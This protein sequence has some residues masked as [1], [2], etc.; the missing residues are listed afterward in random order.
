MN[1]QLT[2]DVQNCSFNKGA[3]KMDVS[4]LPPC[5]G[6]RYIISYQYTDDRYL[7]LL[8]DTTHKRAHV[9]LFAYRGQGL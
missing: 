5:E 8:P 7:S 2:I 9:R 3:V 1:K 6:V 4:V